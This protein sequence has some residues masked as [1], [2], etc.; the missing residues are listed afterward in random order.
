[1]L[2]LAGMSYD[3]RSLDTTLTVPAAAQYVLTGNRVGQSWV[4]RT[5]VDR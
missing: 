4:W 1:V 2:L 5:L 3:R